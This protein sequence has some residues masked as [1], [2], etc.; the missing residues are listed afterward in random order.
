MDDVF[1]VHRHKR[2][3]NALHNDRCVPFVV[4]PVLLDSLEK[5]APVQVLEDQVDVILGFVHLMQVDDVLVVQLAQ[6]G[7]FLKQ[8]ELQISMGL[9]EFIRNLQSSFG[10]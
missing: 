6:N 10:F 3:Q 7:Y 2:F 9:A 8:G 1:S 5:F 4:G